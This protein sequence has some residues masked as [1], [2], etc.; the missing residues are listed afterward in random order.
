M[1]LAFIFILPAGSI[2]DK[3]AHQFALTVTRRD[4][5]QA[6]TARLMGCFGSKEAGIGVKNSHQTNST[7]SRYDG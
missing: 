5:G 4:N 1:A 6:L 2:S 7:E 3:S